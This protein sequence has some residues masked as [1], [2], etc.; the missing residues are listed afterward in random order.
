MGERPPFLLFLFDPIPRWC[1][2]SIQGQFLGSL[3]YNVGSMLAVEGTVLDI[4]F[5]FLAS[6]SS[7]AA[8]PRVPKVPRNL[9]NKMVSTKNV[10]TS[11]S[12][13]DIFGFVLKMSK[14]VFKPCSYIDSNT[15]NPNTILK[16]TFIIQN[17]P[18]TTNYFRQFGKCRN[19]SKTNQFIILY[20]I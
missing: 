7:L 18:K 11:G 2:P 1:L 9:D 14:N 19:I 6:I 5:I 15:Q 20:Y 4:S 17:T 3:W 16:I 10:H 13:L 12:F 8:Q